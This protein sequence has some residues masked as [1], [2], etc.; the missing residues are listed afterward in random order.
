MGEK[1]ARLVFSDLQDTIAFSP[2]ERDQHD[3]IF[4]ASQTDKLAS[5]ISSFRDG[6]FHILQC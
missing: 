3:T 1:D 5:I 6:S 2:K 4:P